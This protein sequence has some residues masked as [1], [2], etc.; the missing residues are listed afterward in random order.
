MPP[1]SAAVSRAVTAAETRRSVA[2]VARQ[3]FLPILGNV[4][5]A[6]FH[7]NIVP[8]LRAG[9][10]RHTAMGRGK[11][12]DVGARFLDSDE[13]V[14]FS[15][16]NCGRSAACFAQMNALVLRR[17]DAQDHGTVGLGKAHAGQVVFRKVRPISDIARDQR[18]DLIGLAG[19]AVAGVEPPCRFAMRFAGFLGGA[20]REAHFFACPVGET[21]FVALLMCRQVPGGQDQRQK[22]G[23][24][25]IG[26]HSLALSVCLT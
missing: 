12:G 13:R 2:E 22:S 18:R 19:E 17:A 14:T 10:L 16:M 24:L 20:R 11:R 9:C 5:F 7:D 21:G 15:D 8:L 4:P 1:S 25:E 3:Q 26:F 6:G 23:G